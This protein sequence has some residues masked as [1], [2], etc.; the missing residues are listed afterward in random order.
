[1]GQNHADDDLSGIVVNLN[2]NRIGRTNNAGEMS[3]KCNQ[4]EFESSE[5]GDLKNHLKMHDKEK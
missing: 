1:M 5:T 4:C 3:N 2:L